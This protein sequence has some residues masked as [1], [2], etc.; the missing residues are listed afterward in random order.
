MIF[1]VILS[2]LPCCIFY[3]SMC[4]MI[5]E[6]LM[7]MSFFAMKSFHYKVT[8]SVAHRH[9]SLYRIMLVFALRGQNQNFYEKCDCYRI[10]DVNS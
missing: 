3:P 2:M 1:F 7:K 5:S 4:T 6:T 9:K 10:I 8:V